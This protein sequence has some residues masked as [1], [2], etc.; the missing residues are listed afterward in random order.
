MSCTHGVDEDQQTIYRPRPV[1]SST[2]RMSATCCATD[3]KFSTGRTGRPHMEGSC[4]SR[5]ER[6]NM[7]L[8][9]AKLGSTD[10]PRN[11]LHLSRGQGWERW[12]GLVPC[13]SLADSAFS[14]HERPYDKLCHDPTPLPAG[15]PCCLW[16]ARAIRTSTYPALPQTTSPRRCMCSET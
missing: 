4:Y 5:A 12:D 13:I 15:H 6:V 3:D 11:A 8:A 1:A 14:R 7:C 2:R 9:R 16:F 10:A